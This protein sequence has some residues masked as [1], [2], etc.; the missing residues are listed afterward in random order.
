MRPLLRGSFPPE[1]DEGAGA[2]GALG[3]GDLEAASTSARRQ[4]DCPPRRERG[5]CTT[6]ALSKTPTPS[7]CN[8]IQNVWGFSAHQ[9]LS[10]HVRRKDARAAV[11]HGGSLYLRRAVRHRPDI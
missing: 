11:V 1:G 5:V 2:P 7:Y 8:E 6:Y 4:E 10:M 3:R 9:V